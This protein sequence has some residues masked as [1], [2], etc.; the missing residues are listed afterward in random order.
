MLWVWSP[1]R[2]PTWPSFAELTGLSAACVGGLDFLHGIAMAGR[3]HFDVIPGATGY[4]D[5]D[6]DAK[7]RWALEYVES[8]DF[9]LVHV[10][11][12]DEEAHRHN[13][14]GKIRA[15]ENVDRAVV[16]PLLERL[17]KRHGA[18]FRLVVCGD[19]GTRCSDGRHTGTPAPYAAIGTG[20]EASGTPAFNENVCIA[21]PPIPSLRFLS[22]LLGREP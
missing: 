16:A 5:T 19:H 14:A 21:T 20:I 4:I 1:S 18:A 6:Y 12:A 7:A 17:V 11:A 22:G 13:W 3:I 8:F 2:K 9:V 15:I 10:N